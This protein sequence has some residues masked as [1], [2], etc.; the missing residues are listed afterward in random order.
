M[1]KQTKAEKIVDRRIEL[2]YYKSCA[3]IQ[4]DAMNIGKV[5]QFGREAIARGVDDDH[6]A[7]SIRTYVENY[8]AVRP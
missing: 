5:F 8:L 4:I 1:A 3:G 2:A 6:L 7:S